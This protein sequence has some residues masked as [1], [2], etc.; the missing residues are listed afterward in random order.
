[1][2][3]QLWYNTNMNIQ[4]IAIHVH[5]LAITMIEKMNPYTDSSPFIL[6]N[7]P[8]MS[9][10]RVLGFSRK[11]YYYDHEYY[12]SSLIVTHLPFNKC[13]Y[14]LHAQ[15]RD[16]ELFLAFQWMKDYW[17][18]RYKVD[19]SWLEDT[20]SHGALQ[21][22][23]VMAGCHEEDLFFHYQTGLPWFDYMPPSVSSPAP[24]SEKALLF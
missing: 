18:T 21:L 13:T 10:S 7:Q 5:D 3:C 12:L 14:T 24:N 11:H 4:S 8:F 16:Y 23:R 9:D 20:S 1:M 22:C 17:C 6:R 15:D 19:P 2:L